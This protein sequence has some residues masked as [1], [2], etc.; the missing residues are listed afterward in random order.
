MT[1]Q[2]KKCSKCQ[3]EIMTGKFCTFCTGKKKR[4]LIICLT[5]F[6]VAIIGGGIFWLSLSN[7]KPNQPSNENSP[8]SPE[9]IHKLP[10]EEPIKPDN[11]IN[12]L[13]DLSPPDPTEDEEKVKKECIKA[14]GGE[15]YYKNVVEPILKTTRYIE[16]SIPYAPRNLPEFIT[17]W[18]ERAKTANQEIFISP[19]KTNTVNFCQ[20]YINPLIERIKN[21]VTWCGWRRKAD[22]SIDWKDFKK[23]L[24]EPSPL[25]S[26]EGY[27]AM[28]KF[29]KEKLNPYL[30]NLIDNFPKVS[31][32]TE[33]N[34]WLSEY[35]NSMAMGETL[36]ELC[37]Q[38]REQAGEKKFDWNEPFYKSFPVDSK[39]IGKFTI[40]LYIFDFKTG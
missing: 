33:L 17:K 32:L 29:V 37:W 2:Q 5:I 27:E 16:T 24:K 18:D 31:S 19:P 25:K 38:M 34:Q 28:K 35:A 30:K 9:N 40:N 13:P 21:H 6:S 22:N 12:I 11:P 10:P 7:Q 36:L 8:P 1:K 14:C 23:R 20:K 15:K 4:I 26:K 3:K 39:E